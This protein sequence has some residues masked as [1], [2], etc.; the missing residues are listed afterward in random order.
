MGQ[1][2]GWRPVNRIAWAPG[3]RDLVWERTITAVDPAA[4]P[5][6]LDAPLTT[7]LDPSF[8]GGTVA[9]SAF[10][11]PIDHVGLENLRCISDYDPVFPRTRSTRESANSPPHTLSAP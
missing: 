6:T 7:A 11:G 1:F 3:S 9:R 10:P 2:S 5:L 4:H 8:G